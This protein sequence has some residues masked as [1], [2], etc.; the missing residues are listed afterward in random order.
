MG[1]AKRYEPEEQKVHSNQC[2]ANGCPLIGTA[3]SSNNNTSRKWFCSFH[4][5]ESDAKRFM[6]VTTGVRQN[7]DLYNWF[8]RL[9]TISIIEFQ[10]NKAKYIPHKFPHLEPTESEDLITYRTRVH[11]ELNRLVF[12][13]QSGRG[14][15]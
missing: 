8:A 1:R 13:N 6:N 14:A 5:Q 11:R 15:A 7:I 4:I 10:E 2:Q 12:L 3:S 9:T